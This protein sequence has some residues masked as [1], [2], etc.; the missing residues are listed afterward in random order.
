M[1]NDLIKLRQDLFSYGLTDHFRVNH[2]K[3]KIIKVKEEIRLIK[4]YEKKGFLD[5]SSE[6]KY[7]KNDKFKEVKAYIIEHPDRKSDR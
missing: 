4:G 2:I 6:L 7:I 1:I 5:Y 3:N